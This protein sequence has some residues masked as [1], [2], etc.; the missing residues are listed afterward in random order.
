MKARI[1]LL[2][3][4]WLYYQEHKGQYWDTLDDIE[5][6][7]T[8]LKAYPSNKEVLKALGQMWKSGRKSKYPKGQLPNNWDKLYL[9][10]ENNED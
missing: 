2:I 7:L 3:E 10:K 1:E 4:V 8:N 5:D 6:E 9:G